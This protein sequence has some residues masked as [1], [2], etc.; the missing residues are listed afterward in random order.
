MEYSLKNK[1]TYTDILSEVTVNP[2]KD[3]EDERASIRLWTRAVRKDDSLGRDRYIK[4]YD[5]TD[6]D[7][8]VLALAY[9]KYCYPDNKVQVARLGN[10]W[11][12][13]RVVNVREDY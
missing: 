12:G 9:I 4:F 11:L 5:N 8:K 13:I 2:F 7:L 10:K 1:V 3:N 6:N